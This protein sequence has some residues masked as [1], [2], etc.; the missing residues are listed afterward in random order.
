MAVTHVESDAPE[1]K[2]DASGPRMMSVANADAF[3]VAVSLGAVR[4]HELWEDGVPRP[5]ER[6]SAGDS[7]IYDL[8]RNPSGHIREPFRIMSFYLP[9]R[10][11]NEMADEH[12]GPR[13]DEIVGS[14]PGARNEDPVMRHLA[15]ALLSDIDHA[16]DA[17]A[18]FLD[19]F[20]LTVCAH[21]ARTYCGMG[22]LKSA[23]RG[24]LAQWQIRRA[25]DLLVANLG[26]NVSISELASEC[27]LSP[28]QF[29]RAFRRTTGMPPHRFL[30]DARV[31]KAKDLLLSSAL[32]LI[33]IALTCGFNTQSHFT[34]VF[35]GLV[36]VSPG[37]WRR[38]HADPRNTPRAIS[39]KRSRTVGDDLP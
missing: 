35:S 17:S 11:L 39:S 16:N 21:V 2:C 3:L 10:T 20:T 7:S 30:L 25:Q 1:V 34:R 6:F 14:R 24:R 31:R 37:T 15:L 32:P 12:A 29:A 4:A 18:L 38:S 22:A 27:R 8:R 23:G 5:V 28:S 13:I 26:G 36:G 33:D 9:L 19:H